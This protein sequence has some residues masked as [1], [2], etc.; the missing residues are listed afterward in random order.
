MVKIRGN[1]NRWMDI[2]AVQKLMGWGSEETDLLINGLSPLVARSSKGRIVINLSDLREYLVAIRKITKSSFGE[3][4][5][6]GKTKNTKKEKS[7]KKEKIPEK[8]KDNK[9]MLLGKEVAKK[10]NIKYKILRKLIKEHGLPAIIH[11]PGYY[12]DP[13]KLEEFLK[14]NQELLQSLKPKKE[15]SAEPNAVGAA[16]DISQEEKG[17]NAGKKDLI[18]LPLSS[19]APVEIPSA[20][21]P[22]AT[23]NNEPIDKPAEG[24]IPDNSPIENKKAEEIAKPENS[25]PTQNDVQNDPPAEPKDEDKSQNKDQNNNKKEEDKNKEDVQCSY[26]TIKK[27]KHGC[28]VDDVA[29]ALNTSIQAPTRWINDK[30]V[31]ATVIAGLRG[32]EWYIEPKSLEAFLLKERNTIVTFSET[33][34]VPKMQTSDIHH[35]AH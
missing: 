19:A 34:G 24:P 26:V 30:K 14:E 18:F 29:M 32:D 5:P 10:L 17:E 33:K 31:I 21:I 15:E 20:E 6:P 13:D 28:K 35:P 27:T 22:P 4:S 23:Q 12:I 2:E 8:E 25:P 9:P 16:K 3:A 11:G 7:P 1:P